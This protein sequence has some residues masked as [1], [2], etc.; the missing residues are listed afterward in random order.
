M[1]YESSL[2]L[3][4]FS[5]SRE[6]RAILGG[7]KDWLIIGNYYV[8]DQGPELWGRQVDPAAPAQQSA[9]GP[10]RCL[11]GNL[12]GGQHSCGG[13]GG[14]VGSSPVSSQVGGKAGEEKEL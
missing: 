10:N 11:C 12:E 1:W 3:K 6:K 4:I 7:V 14:G 8:V 5:L 13:W 9:A 2:S